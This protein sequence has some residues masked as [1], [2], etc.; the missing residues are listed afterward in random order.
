MD[1]YSHIRVRDS[2]ADPDRRSSRQVHRM[3]GVPTSELDDRHHAY[4]YRVLNQ[5]VTAIAGTPTDLST[6]RGL[7]IRAPG[8]PGADI[9]RW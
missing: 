2:D 3:P 9:V 6:R 7:S 1:A 5:A 8:I 4:P